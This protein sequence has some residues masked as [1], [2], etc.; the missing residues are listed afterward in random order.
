MRKQNRR[1][2]IKT[3]IICLFLALILSCGYGFAPK[4]DYIDKRIQNIYVE[5]FDNKTPQAGV[6]N[7]IRTALINQILLNSRFKTVASMEAADAIIKG[8]VVNINTSP[9][10][11]RANTLVA[12][13]RAIVMVDIN[14]R[15]KESGKTIWSAKKFTCQIDYQM[16]DNINL[17]PAARKSAL[18]KLSDDLA[19]KAVNMMMAGF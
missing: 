6:E 7:Y 3:G 19:E 15:E 12:E 14:F 9:L 1:L 16:Q 5:P 11:Y 18:V 8:S 13:E 4:G 17:F 2:I 10:S